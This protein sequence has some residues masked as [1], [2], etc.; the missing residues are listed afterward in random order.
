MLGDVPSLYRKIAFNA[1]ISIC[2]QIL[3]T[4]E[5]GTN[6]PKNIGTN[7]SKILA[8]IVKKFQCKIACAEFWRIGVYEALSEV[9]G[10]F[11]QSG[12]I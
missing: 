6:K 2:T 1:Q 10:F 4:L 11:F 9:H 3:K 7:C 8:Q 5:F 12:L